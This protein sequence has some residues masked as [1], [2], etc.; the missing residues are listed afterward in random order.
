M[1]RNEG[2]KHSRS[3]CGWP[4]WRC[5]NRKWGRSRSCR[6]GR[7]SHSLRWG[8]L[9]L[10]PVLSFFHHQGNEGAQG[11]AA[12]ALLHLPKMC[13]NDW[14]WQC[15]YTGNRGRQP[16]LFVLL[17]TSARP[18]LLTSTTLAVTLPE[19]A[20]V[21]VEITWPVHTRHHHQHVH[22]I[23]VGW[24]GATLPSNGKHVVTHSAAHGKPPWSHT[25]SNI[26][27]I[28]K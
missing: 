22:R 4:R 12:T 16:Q 23:M 13:F 8:D 17:D 6:C 27:M 15:N 10:L 9:H 7:R 18:G 28:I 21:N 25:C 11:H 2:Q 3:W 1:W 20:G 26:L 14:R 24:V 5:C 19:K